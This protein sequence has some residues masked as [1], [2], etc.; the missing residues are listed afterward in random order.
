VS[1]NN[2][3]MAMLALLACAG[4]MRAEVRGGY[5]ASCKPPDD[6]H[7]IA[8]DAPTACYRLE[9]KM[10]SD[11]QGLVCT[12]PCKTDPD[13]GAGFECVVQGTPA[14]GGITIRVCTRAH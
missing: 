1:K 3:A 7:V 4:P 6:A 14:G 13:C 11:D 8:C 12:K 5:G 2:V 10:P 9:S